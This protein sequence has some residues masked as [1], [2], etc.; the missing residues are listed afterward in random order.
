[1]NPIKRRWD[2]A[3]HYPN[4]P[5]APHHVHLDDGTVEESPVNPTMTFVIVQIEQEMKAD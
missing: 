3:P 5:N 1:M 4:W 2:N